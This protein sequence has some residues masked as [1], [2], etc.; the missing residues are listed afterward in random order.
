M[1]FLK[2]ISVIFAYFFLNLSTSFAHNCKG[3]TNLDSVTFDKIVDKFTTTLIKFDNY[4]AFTGGPEYKTFSQVALDLAAIDDLLVAEV[5]LLHGGGKDNQDLEQRYGIT[6]EFYSPARQRPS[7][8]LFHKDRTKGGALQHYKFS[9]DESYEVDSIKHFITQK[10][11]IWIGL[12]GCLREFD[13]YAKIFLN[14]ENAGDKGKAMG[15][16][17][18]AVLKLDVASE[19]KVAAEIYVKLMRK[20]VNAGNEFAR[21]ELK[22]VKKLL[23]GGKQS[24]NKKR[25]LEQRVNIIRSFIRD[26]DYPKIGK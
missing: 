5:Q 2:L 8:M 16:A 9:E 21:I 18:K 24:D 6:K 3:C 25:Q 23:G 26:P 1:T 15:W 20:L 11:G 17:E 19:E 10:T 4:H 7:L 14:S 22:R 13:L 12:P